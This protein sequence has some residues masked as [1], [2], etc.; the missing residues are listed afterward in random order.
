[1]ADI[2]IAVAGLLHEANT[3]SPLKTSLNDFIILRG[4]K[5]IR[6]L[7]A[8]RFFS[9]MNAQTVPILYA[10]ALP[11][12][13]VTRETFETLAGEILR[14]IKAALPL[15]GICLYLHGAMEVHRL[16]SGEAELVSRVR[17]IAGKTTPI[18]VAL[19]FHANN[20]SRFVAACNVICGYRTAPHVDQEETQRRA[21][22]LLMQCIQNKWLPHPVMV[23]IP[24][25]TPG[26]ALATTMDPGR[27]LMSEAMQTAERSDILFAE[28]FGGDPW[29]D[30]PNMGPSV[31]VASV[32]DRTPAKREANR[33]ANL[34]WEAREQFHFE[35]PAAQ[36][37]EAVEWALK[38]NDGPVFISD[39]GD[40]TTG[41]APGDNACLLG[42]FLTR[43]VPKTLL[44][45]ITDAPAVMAC[46]GLSLGNRFCH[47]IGG[48]LDPAHSCSLTVDGILKSKG[49]L[50]GWTGEDAGRC[51][52]ID[53]HGVDILITE[54]PCGIISQDILLSAG[55]K[56][57]EYQIIVVKLGYLWDDLRKIAKH[58]IMALTPGVTCEAV[59]NINYQNLVR[60]VYP[61]DG[62]FDWLIP[63]YFT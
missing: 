6:K 63:E 12:G 29:V 19:D 45:G 23:H 43:Q 1:M 11:S 47:A 48:T 26:Q 34:F 31:I 7:E 42:L 35:V 32:N 36:P 16:G 59:E 55:V 17:E 33:L 39:T 56:A 58:S 25:V 46:D 60:P 18:A 61:L 53:S 24:M 40:N 10:E 41:G 50:A 22:R 2:K 52:V 38:K 20:T 21:A 49:R 37:N 9:E 27:R 4:A 15:D 57:K 5:S 44:A 54:R 8:A 28:I 13:E 14:G 62:D 51:A 30:V 3:F